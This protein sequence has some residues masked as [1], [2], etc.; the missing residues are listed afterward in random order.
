MGKFRARYPGRSRKLVVAFDIGTSF[1]GAAYALLE[2]GEIP[3]IRSV[4]RQVL[5]VFADLVPL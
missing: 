3:R 2:P 5:Q 1:S 4:K